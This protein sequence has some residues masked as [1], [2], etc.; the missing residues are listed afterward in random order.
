[1]NLCELDN[2]RLLQH[3]QTLQRNEYGVIENN[4]EHFYCAEH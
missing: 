2:A 4:H 1:M 3:S